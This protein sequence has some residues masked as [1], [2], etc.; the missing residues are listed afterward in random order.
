M[1]TGFI[2][3]IA[4][5]AIGSAMSSMGGSGGGGSQGGVPQGSSFAAGYG[6]NPGAGALKML[7]PQQAPSGLVTGMGAAP[8]AQPPGLLEKGLQAIGQNIQ[9]QIGQGPIGQIM[10]LISRDQQENQQRPV[11]AVPPAI[12]NVGQQAQNWFGSTMFR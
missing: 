10:S 7:Q 8:Q 1:S 11:S 5:N 3:G 12:P 6:Q 9:S 4:S 2:T